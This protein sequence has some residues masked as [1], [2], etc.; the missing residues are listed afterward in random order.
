METK[1][2]VYDPETDKTFVLTILLDHL[3]G[4]DGRVTKMEEEYANSKD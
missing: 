2:R 1:Q 4:T 3:V